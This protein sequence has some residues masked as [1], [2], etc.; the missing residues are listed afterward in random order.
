MIHLNLTPC[1][2]PLWHSWGASLVAPF[3]SSNPQKIGGE[4]TW[5]HMGLELV[6]ASWS[7]LV[8]HCIG[9]WSANWPERRIW[10]DRILQWTRSHKWYPIVC[11][12][13]SM[14]V[15]WCC[16]HVVQQGHLTPAVLIKIREGT[17]V[18]TWPTSQPKSVNW[19]LHY[20][21]QQISIAGGYRRLSPAPACSAIND[22][23]LCIEP[24][25]WWEHLSRH[26]LVY[27]VTSQY[28][29]W[30]SSW[31]P[32]L[33]YLSSEIAL[34][35]LVPIAGNIASMDSGSGE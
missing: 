18:Y 19:Q 4:T 3:V 7:L 1:V 33:A 23:G 6:F 16:Y 30:C 8:H 2:I 24:K 15:K 14:M 17:L 26:A 21:S 12:M 9:L 35:V 29:C 22:Q 13:P 27:V 25:P 20:W 28:Y 31:N 32:R 5:I 34:V 10:I 11:E